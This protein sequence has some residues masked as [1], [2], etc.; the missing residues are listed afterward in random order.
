[1]YVALTYQICSR[2]SACLI[3]LV[4]PLVGLSSDD[5]YPEL[6]IRLRSGIRERGHRVMVLGLL[7][8]LCVTVLMAHG[9]FG[10]GHDTEAGDHAMQNAVSVC[11]AIVEVLAIGVLLAVWRPPALNRPL[12]ALGVPLALNARAIQGI[13]GRARAGPA[14]LQVF[15]L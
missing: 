3:Q 15:R 8:F 11:L 9:A 10:M 6:M 5:R 7:S 4:L 2:V 1:M 13:A 12:R 14:T